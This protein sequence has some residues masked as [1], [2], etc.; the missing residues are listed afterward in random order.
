MKYCLNPQCPHVLSVGS[1]PEYID[2][3]TVCADCGTELIQRDSPPSQVETPTL[4]K[5]KI[6]KRNTLAVFYKEKISFV[7]PLLEKFYV[8]AFPCNRTNSQADETHESQQDSWNVHTQM[9]PGDYFDTHA[10]L[11]T[12]AS[13]REPHFAHLAK[14]K[15]ESEGILAA[16]GNENIVNMNWFYSNAVGGVTL[17]VLESHARRALEILESISSDNPGETSL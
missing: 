15:L 13:Y 8:W 12:I 3:M 4:L 17:Q 9:E 10:S 6:D 5:G 14:S 1:P 16:V 2:D 11:V 7:K